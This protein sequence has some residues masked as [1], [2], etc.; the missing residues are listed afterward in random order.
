M[1]PAALSDAEFL[2][3]PTTR[4]V[5][6]HPLHRVYW[7]MVYRCSNPAHPQYRRWGGRG[8]TVCPTWLEPL[9]AGL[10]NYVADLGPK[11]DDGQRWTVDR[12][13]NDGPYCGGRCGGACGYGTEGNVRWATYSEQST[14][15]RLKN[16]VCVVC[17]AQF[18]AMLSHAKYCSGTCSQRAARSRR[19]HQ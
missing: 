16:L 4:R 7:E 8:I 12:I 14:N 15:R 18:T 10:A 19:R 17:G 5:G 11:P 6:R 9:G 2:A 1:A 3:V 13:D